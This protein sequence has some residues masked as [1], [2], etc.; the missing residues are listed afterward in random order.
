MGDFFKGTLREMYA[1]IYGATSFDAA[2]QFLDLSDSEGSIYHGIWGFIHSIYTLMA[3]IGIILTLIHFYRNLIDKTT[4]QEFTLEVFG[5][6]CLLM[7]LTVAI[8]SFG[9]DAI[10]SMASAGTGLY[11]DIQGTITS[12]PDTEDRLAKLNETIDKM[13]IMETIGA[14]MSVFIFSVIMKLANILIIV[15]TLSRAV[16]F[17][18]YAMFAP[19]GM[20]DL[21]ANGG[22]SSG[23]RYIKKLCSVTLQSSVIYLI[24]ISAIQIKG[25]FITSHSEEIKGMADVAGASSGTLLLVSVGIMI[26]TVAVV[27]KSMSICDEIMGV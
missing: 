11:N 24:C 21:Y 13:G 17:M 5:K 18:I 22:A 8:I 10:T 12:S 7:V 1:E 14:Y 4:R 9:F 2:T 19:V 16:M 26:A 23:I 15:A 20:S 6:E 27:F 3:I 25:S